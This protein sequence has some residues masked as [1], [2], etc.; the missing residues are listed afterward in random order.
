METVIA[1]DGERIV[2]HS[3]G[4]GPDV[5]VVHGGGVTI[6]PYRRLAAALTD[7]HTVHLYNRRGRADAPARREPYSVQQEIE[8]LAAVLTHT[9]ART[10]VGHSSGGFIALRAALTLPIARLALYDPAVSVDGIFKAEFVPRAR[11]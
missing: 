8:D 2:L 10:V 5:V 7:H 4:T 6:E 1:P 11:A 9:G 3:S